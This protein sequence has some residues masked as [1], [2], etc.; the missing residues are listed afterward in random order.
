MKKNREP[1]FFFAG[2]NCQTNID[3]CKQNDQ[4]CENGATCIDG[5]VDYTCNCKP[6]YTGRNCTVDIDE[7]QFGFCQNNATCSQNHTIN[8]YTCACLAGFTDFNCSTNINECEPNPCVN[9]TNCTDLIND[10]NCTC[11]PGFT[12]NILHT[13][14]KMRETALTETV[15]YRTLHEACVTV[16]WCGRRRG[17][18]SREG[19]RDQ[20]LIT[21]SFCLHLTLDCPESRSLM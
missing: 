8:N 4:P 13:R 14:Y 7:C 10:F 16:T 5:I 18:E 3:D 19:G 21:L 2:A 11:L 20:N 12:G 15:L 1:F 17:E 9:S 6:G